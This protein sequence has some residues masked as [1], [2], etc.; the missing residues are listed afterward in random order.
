MRGAIRCSPAARSSSPVV[1]RRHSPENT[2]WLAMANSGSSSVVGRSASSSTGMPRRCAAS[3]S[4]RTMSGKRLSASSSA[5]P[6][7]SASGSASCA[8]SI[9]GSRWVTIIR[10]PAASTMIPDTGAV[11]PATRTTPAG[12]DALVRHRGDQL[13][14]GVVGHVAERAGIAGAAA[15][16]RHRDRGVDRAAAGD[17]DEIVRH[18]LA[19]RRR[20]RVDPEH[21]VLHRDA[22]AQDHR[23]ARRRHRRSPPRC[24]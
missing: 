21:D 7:T 18:A 4:G 5:M 11:A 8:L 19:A 9:R 10:S 22:G 15:K 20:E 6:S 14:A 2:T 17:G 23:R 12:V 1:S 24:G 16:P 13:V 3:H